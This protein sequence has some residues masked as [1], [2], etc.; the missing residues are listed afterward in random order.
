M[1][2]FRCCAVVPTFENPETIRSVVEAIRA[3]L[4]DVLVIDDGSS[5]AGHA[6]CAALSKEGLAEVRHLPENRGKG[7]AMRVGFAEAARMG[8]THAFQIDAD[9]QHDAKAIPAFLE[10]A[11]ERPEC[12]VFARP[13]YDDTIPAARRIARKI[14]HFWVNL[15]VGRGVIEDALI[16]FR[17]YPLQAT[18]SLGLVC[19]RMTFDVESAVLLAWAGVPIVNRPVRVRYLTEAEGGRSHFHVVRDNLRLSW[20]HCRLCTTASI[21]FCFGRPVRRA[22]SESS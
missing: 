18:L 13:V 4:P 15:E 12:A 1:S 17:I 8:F 22:L 19:N 3:Y 14:T 21:R 16:G 6:A 2:E 20:L 9:G 5:A 11:R 7:A 10:A